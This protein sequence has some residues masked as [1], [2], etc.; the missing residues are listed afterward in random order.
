MYTRARS[1]T[2]G[3]EDTLNVRLFE[4]NFPKAYFLSRKKLLE[5]REGQLELSSSLRWARQ[6]MRLARRQVRGSHL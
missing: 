2:P 4:S 5:K 1:V 6:S 3:E